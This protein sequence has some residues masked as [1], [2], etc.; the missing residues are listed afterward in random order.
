MSNCRGCSTQEEVAEAAAARRAQI[1]EWQVQ[2]LAYDRE[3]HGHGAYAN[4][5]TVEE[6]QN[7][8][9]DN[10]WSEPANE[11]QSTEAK[12]GELTLVGTMEP[13]PDVFEPATEKEAANDTGGSFE[14]EDEKKEKPT[15]KKANAATKKAAVKS[16][17]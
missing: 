2:Q 5:V 15:P 3:A 13:Q 1:K 4:E 9:E 10:F 6:V 7:D 12:G 14:E 17:D 16:N 8:F 11:G